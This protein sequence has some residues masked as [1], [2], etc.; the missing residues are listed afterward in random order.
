MADLSK[1]LEL[2]NAINAA[3]KERAGHYVAIVFSAGC[4]VKYGISN[5]QYYAKSKY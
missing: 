1:Q 5:A 4:S 3:L 2:Q